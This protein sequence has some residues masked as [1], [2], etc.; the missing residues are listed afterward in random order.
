MGVLHFKL[1]TVC[2]TAGKSHAGTAINYNK[3]AK[4]N[5]PAGKKISNSGN[6]TIKQQGLLKK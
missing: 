4:A 5:R 1:R 6:K 3:S 2:G